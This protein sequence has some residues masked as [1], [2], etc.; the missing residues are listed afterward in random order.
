MGRFRPSGNLIIGGQIFHTDAVTETDPYVLT[1]G[2]ANY[3]KPEPS[4]GA[5]RRSV[6]YGKLPM[7]PYTRRYA[8]RPRLAHF[9]NAPPYEAVKASIKQF[10]IHHDG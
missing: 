1:P 6:P 9:K 4:E 5:G 3:C 8:L 2:N 10:V 7:G